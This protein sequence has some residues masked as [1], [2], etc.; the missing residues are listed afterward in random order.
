MT[1]NEM[2]ESPEA[3]EAAINAFRCLT[4]QEILDGLRK[5]IKQDLEDTQK[6]DIQRKFT[7]PECKFTS[8]NPND[9]KFSYCGHCHKF[10]CSSL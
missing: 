10:W 8:E 7:C 2:I 6:H 4:S 5:R 1:D 9:S 3:V